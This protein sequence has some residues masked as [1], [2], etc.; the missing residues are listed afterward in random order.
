MKAFITLPNNKCSVSTLHTRGMD[1]RSARMSHDFIIV[2]G[3]SAGSVLATRLTERSA[4][5]VLLFEAGPNI[6]DGETPERILDSF[7]A[8]AF[9]D[10]RFLWNDLRVTTETVPHNQPDAA[11]PRLRKY[12]QARVLGGGSSINGAARQPRRP[13]RLRRVGDAW[14]RRLELELGPSLFPQART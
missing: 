1:T 2:G 14:R 6:K 13:R 5:S 4:T 8:Y 9:L 11:R 7:A 10:R 3:G 12:E